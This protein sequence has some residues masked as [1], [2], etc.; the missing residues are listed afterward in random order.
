MGIRP[1]FVEGEGAKLNYLL[2]SHK[3]QLYYS[4]IWL[5]LLKPLKLSTAFFTE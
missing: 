2:Q 4:E 5:K 3:N 1:L